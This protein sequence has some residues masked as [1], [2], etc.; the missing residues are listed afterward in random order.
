[1]YRYI[2]PRTIAYPEANIMWR[3]YLNI[4]RNNV[5]YLEIGS[6]H[7]G[8]LLM[9]HNMFGPNVHSTSIDPFCDCDYYPEYTTEHESNFEIY[10]INTEQLGDKNVHIRKPSY[11]V[12][13]TLQNDFFD[14]I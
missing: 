6:L 3:D 12:L 8:S 2:D 10:N 1:M 9:F 11:E 4:N 13:P 14:T 5:E 7:G